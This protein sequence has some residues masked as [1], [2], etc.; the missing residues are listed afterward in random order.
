M[1]LLAPNIKIVAI[2]SH[3]VV[4]VLTINVSLET[5]THTDIPS[6]R[7][8]MWLYVMSKLC[9]YSWHIKVGREWVCISF[10]LISIR[11]LYCDQQMSIRERKQQFQ[12]VTA[13]LETCDFNIVWDI[14]WPPNA[15]SSILLTSM[16]VSKWYV[17]CM[18][19]VDINISQIIT[20]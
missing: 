13:M 16:F 6:W 9:W 10:I 8:V 3:A 18:L 14:W 11:L 7:C 1:G 17:Y 15:H 4:H 20:S 19:I 12:T 2:R 5:Y